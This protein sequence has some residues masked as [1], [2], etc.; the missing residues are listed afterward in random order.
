MPLTIYSD[1]QLS[2]EKLQQK[3]RSDSIHHRNIQTL[4]TEMYKVKSGYTP[5]IFSD[6]FNQRKI[7]SCNLRRHPE[8]RVPF[9]RTVYH[10]SESI[11]YLGQKYEIFSQHHLR[12]HFP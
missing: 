10:G 5:N 6:L 8:F 12:K 2:Y 11:S 9:T 4:A 3:D 1:K 7:S